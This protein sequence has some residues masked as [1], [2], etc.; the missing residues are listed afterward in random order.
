MHPT[1]SK[2]VSRR[3]MLRV[4]AAFGITGPAAIEM[5]AQAR[6]GQLS[7]EIMKMSNALIDQE[8]SE[9]RL[10]VIAAA[11]QRNLEQFQVVRNLDIDDSIEPAPLFNSR[12]R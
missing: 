5:A 3:K 10:R 8:F 11:V 9:E 12:A 2:P 4:L 6:S 1:N 7:P